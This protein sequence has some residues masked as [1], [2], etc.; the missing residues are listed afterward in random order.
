M[1]L[2]IFSRRFNSIAGV[3]IKRGNKQT[4]Q[5]VH[6]FNIENISKIITP[7]IIALEQAHINYQLITI[8]TN[9]HKREKKMKKTQ[10]FNK[11]MFSIINLDFE[12]T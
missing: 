11:K 1:S 4:H 9:T 8:K 2:I 7:A 3:V 12:L 10:I 5:Y 6:N